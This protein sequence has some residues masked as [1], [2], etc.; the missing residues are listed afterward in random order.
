[1]WRSTGSA[2]TWRA[3]HEPRFRSGDRDD[4]GD[5]VRRD[6]RRHPG[7]DAKRGEESRRETAGRSPSSGGRFRR[8]EIPPIACSSSRTNS[9]NI[10]TGA[11]STCSSRRGSSSR[12]RS[13]RSPSRRRGSPRSR[14]PGGRG[15]FRTDD[16]YSRARIVSIE[17]TRIQAE[18][19]RDR[20]VVV[21]GVPGRERSPGCHHPRTGRIRHQRGRTCRGAPREG[22]RDPHRRRRGLHRR[23][24]G[25]PLRT[26]ARAA[27]IR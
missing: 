27:F 23:S 20:V 6:E 5:E 4:L 25:R 11:N 14:L 7:A 15:G 26:Q 16:R 21:A 13:S 10:R 18:L 8:W 2:C 9:R 24:P 3:G 1:M 22:L 12:W 17:P 19:D